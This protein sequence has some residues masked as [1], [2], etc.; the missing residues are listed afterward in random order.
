[1]TDAQTS[2]DL[3]KWDPGIKNQRIKADCAEPKAIKYYRDE[4]FDM[5]PCKKIAESRKEGS[6]IANTKKMKRFNR[7]IC[8]SECINTIKECK[9]LTYKK[10]KQGN[11]QL[12]TFNIDPHTFSAMWYALDDYNVS[13]YKL[14]K[15]HSKRGEVI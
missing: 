8:S 9:D 14:R 2:K 10:D 1:M 7:I 4:G 15:S 3:V 13:D 5:I 11:V 6:R 12:G